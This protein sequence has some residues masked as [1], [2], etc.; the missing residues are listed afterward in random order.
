MDSDFLVITVLKITILLIG[1]MH[2]LVESERAKT[3]P[4]IGRG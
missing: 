4:M 3:L 1:L 2:M